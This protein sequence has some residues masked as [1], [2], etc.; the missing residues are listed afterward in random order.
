MLSNAG[1][2]KSFC[3][4]AYA[5]HLINRLSSSAIKGKTPLEVWSKKV[6]QD[7]DSLHVFGCPAYYHI[8]KDKLNPG[9]RKGVF[10]GCQ[11]RYERLQNLGSKW[12]RR[13]S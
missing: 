11:E 1:L 12:I 5:C 10:M 3:L 8:K 9:E 7:Y 6:A 2:S 13:S 4:K